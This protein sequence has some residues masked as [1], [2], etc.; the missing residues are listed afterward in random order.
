MNAMVSTFPPAPSPWQRLSHRFSV[1]AHAVGQGLANLTTDL[2]VLSRHWHEGA[3]LR[4]KHLAKFQMIVRADE[5]VGRAIYYGGTHEAFET[6]FFESR[7]LA[8]STCFDIG[9][10]IGYFSLLF[11]SLASQGA[12]HSFEPV[13]LNFHVL[14]T[15]RLLNDFANLVVNACALGDWNGKVPFVVSRDSAFS[16]LMD[17]GMKPVATEI[18]VPMITLD[19]YCEKNGIDTI[20]VLKADVEGAES[21]VIA[22]AARLLGDRSRR[23]HT[24]MLE[25]Y[26]PM[27][28][29]YGTS[30][31][32]L[33]Y[34]MHQYGYRPH[35]LVN[36]RLVSFQREHY[37]QLYNVIFL[38]A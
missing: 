15:N 34:K 12:V 35:V 24:V 17:T 26:E 11:A 36:E 6:A 20:D 4:Q 1:G 5:E 22:G 7:I 27:L 10:N 13:P 23:P 16:S 37:N 2:A 3:I 30:I 33:L 38:D 25:M 8:N 21:K 18:S 19:S 28:A 29:R 9:A 32:E 31:D 14:C